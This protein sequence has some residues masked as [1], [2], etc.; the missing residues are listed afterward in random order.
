MV[1]IKKTDAQ[2]QVTVL[3]GSIEGDAAVVL[4]DDSEFLPALTLLAGSSQWHILS[5]LGNLDSLGFNAS[6]EQLAFWN[7]DSSFTVDNTQIAN[8]GTHDESPDSGSLMATTILE[9]YNPNGGKT[10]IKAHTSGT[11]LNLVGVENSPN[12]SWT[13][14]HKNTQAD[15]TRFSCGWSGNAIQDAKLSFDFDRRGTASAADTI[16]FQAKINDGSWSTPSITTIYD[17]GGANTA[18]SSAMVDVTG[19]SSA[20]G[21]WATV[22]IDF[23]STFTTASTS[24]N[25]RL[26]IGKSNSEFS[27]LTL[28]NHF[29]NFLLEGKTVSLP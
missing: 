1:K 23:A 12:M 22:E 4:S 21:D 8:A 9:T 5:S 7:L 24:G 26:I 29:D 16:E 2:N 28:G 17:V 10:H 18:G 27:S 15:E 20:V 14:T 3:G 13:M 19:N 11:N 6:S 25:I